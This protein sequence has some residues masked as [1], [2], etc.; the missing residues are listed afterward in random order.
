M[1]LFSRPNI[2][3]DILKIDET[4]LTELM[5]P[6][7]ATLASQEIERIIVY[8]NKRLMK[9]VSVVGAEAMGQYDAKTDGHLLVDHYTRGC[10]NSAKPRF[11]QTGCT[12]QTV[13]VNVSARPTHWGWDWI[14]G[15]FISYM[16]WD[17]VQPSGNGFR[18]S[19][20]WDAMESLLSLYS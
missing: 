19:V 17:F 16:T 15:I 14:C 1:G 20:D 18:N 8:V 6:M 7:M 2:F 3:L 12:E 10:Q 9:L 11:W 4:N 5:A 13:S